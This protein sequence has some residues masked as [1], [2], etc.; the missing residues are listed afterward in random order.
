MTDSYAPS[1]AVLVQ[2]F[3]LTMCGWIS[4]RPCQDRQGCSSEA[5]DARMAV[6]YHWRFRRH[7]HGG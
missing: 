5:G 4:A 7:H 1:V 2:N 6:Q 3:K